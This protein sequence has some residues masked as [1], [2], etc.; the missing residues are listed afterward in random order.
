MDTFQQKPKVGCSNGSQRCI[1]N[2][3]QDATTSGAT[4]SRR[5]VLEPRVTD[6]TGLDRSEGKGKT[7][8]RKPN[9]KTIGLEARS[10]CLSALLRK[11]AVHCYSPAERKN[12]S[13]YGVSRSFRALQVSRCER[14]N[15][16]VSAQ[17]SSGVVPQGFGGF[18]RVAEGFGDYWASVV[19]LTEVPVI[20][21]PLVG[22]LDWFGD[23]NQTA[24]RPRNH[25][26][27]SKPP[28]FLKWVWVSTTPPEKHAGFGLCFHLLG[29]APFCGCAIFDTQPNGCGSNLN[30][31]GYAGVGPGFHLPGQA[32][33][34]PF[35]A[36]MLGLFT[37]CQLG[38]PYQNTKSLKTNNF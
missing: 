38:F 6:S 16:P 26:L 2:K 34:V 10:R 9:G 4:E 22:G 8:N 17:V 29:L 14:K 23:L 32:I 19:T 28:Y 20:R 21:Y 18:R 13:A 31:R 33:L 3:Q 36:W 12:A 11:F 1:R 15:P 25:R 30:R 24:P 27:G 37:F 35:F 5:V 7:G